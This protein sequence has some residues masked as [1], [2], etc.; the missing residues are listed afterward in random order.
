MFEESEVPAV[1]ARAREA[2]VAAVVVPAT[3]PDDLPVALRLAERFPDAIRVGVGIHPHDARLLDGSCKR[4]VE[5]A[6]RRPGVVAIGEIGLDYHYMNSPREDQIDAFEWHLDLAIES[7]LPVIIHNRDSWEDMERLLRSRAGRLRGVCHSFTESPERARTVQ[8][9]G[10]YVG[11]SGMITFRKATN[12]RTLAAAVSM[13]RMLVETDSPFLA[14]VP[15][16]GRRNEPAWVVEVGRAV[17]AE[18]DLPIAEAAS[19]TTR[20]V[21]QLFG[22]EP[23]PTSAA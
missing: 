15:H 10:L 6:R 23:E 20:N 3:N 22:F 2:G 5:T 8:Q 19:Q 4:T 16:R 1:L 17:A 14:P 21:S 11:I 9:L 13:D 18:H 7:D 12:I